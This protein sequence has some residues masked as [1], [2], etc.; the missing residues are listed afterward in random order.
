LIS[1]SEVIVSIWRDCNELIGKKNKV[2][3]LVIASIIFISQ[4]GVNYVVSLSQQEH[5]TDS[6]E[7]SLFW[8]DHCNSTTDWRRQ[9]YGSLF[10]APR[11]IITMGNLIVHPT[12]LDSLCFDNYPL[13]DYGDTGPFYVKE[14]GISLSVRSISH[15]QV[16]MEYD[17]VPEVEGG[18]SI[19][20]YDENQ[21]LVF[22]FS[23]TDDWFGYGIA[24]RIEYFP[25]GSHI[26]SAYLAYETQSTHPT[27]EYSI[28][29]NTSTGE[30]LAGIASDT[31]VSDVILQ[32]DEFNSSRNL[33]YVGI[34][35][36]CMPFT[37]ENEKLYCLNEIEFRYYEPEVIPTTETTQI[38][39]PIPTGSETVE[40]P[41]TDNEEPVLSDEPLPLVT[42]IARSISAGSLVVIA[43]VVMKSIQLRNRYISSD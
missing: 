36:R 16:Q 23:L 34:Q 10:P 1:I 3:I 31:I 40:T 42:L 41:P 35:G 32:P 2:S 7:D 13:D 43:I 27:I 37:T 25:N 19:C 28:R 9:S 14:L 39:R 38:T 24:A 29:Y 5:S 17:Y 20:F 4:T 11:H 8:I 6:F 26:R 30:I 22:C 12:R 33:Q 21:W 15:L 18:L